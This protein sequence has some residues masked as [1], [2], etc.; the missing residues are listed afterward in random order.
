MAD[1]KVSLSDQRTQLFVDNGL[2]NIILMN[3]LCLIFLKYK[4]LSFYA[5]VILILDIYL[6]YCFCYFPE[7]LG[8]FFISVKS[9]LFID[10]C[11]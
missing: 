3:V 10:F 5:N 4:L 7:I 11:R 1:G 6:E 8:F 2:K 9:H